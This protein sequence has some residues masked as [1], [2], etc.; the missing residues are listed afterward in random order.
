MVVVGL[1]VVGVDGTS[2]LGTSLLSVFV[3]RVGDDC[4]CRV[5][6]VAVVVVSAMVV[7]S[8]GAAGEEVEEIRL[9]VVAAVLAVLA[10]L[11]TLAAPDLAMC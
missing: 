7:L 3:S 11:T 10:V 6:A 2:P 5:T 8:T 4:L 1:V 9:V